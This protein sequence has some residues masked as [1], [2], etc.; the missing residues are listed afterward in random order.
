[1]PF[2]NDTFVI[3]IMSVLRHI[4]SYTIYFAEQL[5]KNKYGLKQSYECHKIYNFY[6]KIVIEY[7]V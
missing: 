2:T 7:E 1:M 4:Y 5:I 3:Q 6:N